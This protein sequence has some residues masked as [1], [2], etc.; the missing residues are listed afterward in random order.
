MATSPRGRIPAGSGEA[1]LATSLTSLRSAVPRTAEVVVCQSRDP[2]HVDGGRG[3]TS[4][5]VAMPSCSTCGT[6]IDRAVP[7]CAKCGTPTTAAQAAEPVSTEASPR[8]VAT[9]N[10][11]ST[12]SG[13]QVVYHEQ[14]LSID[15]VFLSAG[16]LLGYDQHGWLDLAQEDLRWWV[17]QVSEWE[18]A[19]QPQTQTAGQPSSEAEDFATGTSTVSEEE[20][21]PPTEPSRMEGPAC[22]PYCAVAVEP[23]PR[24]SQDRRPRT[25]DAS[26]EAGRH[27][28]TPPADRGRRR[29]ERRGLGAVPPGR[30]GDR[31]LTR[32]TLKLQYRPRGP[33]R[34][35]TGR[36]VAR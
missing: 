16:K 2:P 35:T 3:H 21:E 23:P 12:W 15:G 5:G 27:R 34:L 13:R 6:P 10:S 30:R 19:S 32:R 20:D 18:G 7:V 25:E 17:T 1:S 26:E 22:C 14:R 8:L 4:R 24:A 29:N 11:R 31:P 9:F 28:R 33:R 36:I